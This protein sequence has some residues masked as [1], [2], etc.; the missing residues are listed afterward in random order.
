MLYFCYLGKTR[1]ITGK[2]N[3]GINLKTEMENGKIRTMKK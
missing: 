1:A 2:K 3:E